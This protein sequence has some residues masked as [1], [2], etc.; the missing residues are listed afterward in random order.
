MQK[1]HTCE[2]SAKGLRTK[3]ETI[4]RQEESNQRA[5]RGPF[6]MEKDGVERDTYAGQ[7]RLF[8]MQLRPRR[9]GVAAMLGELDREI[10]KV[11]VELADL[12][13]KPREGK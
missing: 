5:P 10:S 11:E 13:K 9:S 6:F 8:L 4:N 7:L 3:P 1:R 2:L 12:N